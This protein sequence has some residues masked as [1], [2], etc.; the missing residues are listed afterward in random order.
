MKG[1]EFFS[2]TVTVYNRM[3]ARESER[4][5]AVMLTGVCWQ[6]Q[7]AR[8]LGGK[9][10]PSAEETGAGKLYIPFDVVSGRKA[11]CPPELFDKLEK[12]APAWTLRPGDVVCKGEGPLECEGSPLRM[13]AGKGGYTVT[14]VAVHDAPENLAHWEVTVQ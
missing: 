2:Q 5:E 4:W 9:A 8:K 11:Y 3:E 12:E 10:M 7:Y 14:A 1:S 13:L 6:E